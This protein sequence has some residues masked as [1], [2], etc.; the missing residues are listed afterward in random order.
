MLATNGILGAAFVPPLRSPQGLAVSQSTLAIAD[1][2]NHQVVIVDLNAPGVSAKRLGA[3]GSSASAEGF[4]FPGAVVFTAA[5]RL[6]VADS[7]NRHLDRYAR[8]VGGWA[9]QG[10]VAPFAGLNPAVSD[11]RDVC[12][13]TATSL[14][15]LEAGG[16]LLSVDLAA[17]TATVVLADN[18]WRRPVTLARGGN[19]LWVVDSET[20]TVYEYD[21]AF[22]PVRA[23]GGFGANAGRLRTPLGLVPDLAGG[24]LYV[25]EGVGGRIS[26]FDLAGVPVEQLTLPPDAAHLLGR[27]ALAGAGRLLFTDAGANRVQSVTTVASSAVALSL[28]TIEFGPVGLGYRLIGTIAVR[29]GGT[30]PLTVSAV[31]V[32][33]AAFR[34]DATAPALPA[35]VTG[36]DAL[37]LPIAFAPR[38]GGRTFG[39]IL[40]TT[41]SAAAPVL[42]ARLSGEGRVS[43]PVAIGLVLDT[44]GSM[45]QS[46]GALTKMLRLHQ[47]ADLAADLLAST[48]V[49]ELS[50]TRFS[51][52]ASVPF[53]RATLAAA[54]VNGAHQAID[55]LVPGG[56]TSIGAG[57]QSALADLATT[58]LARRSL[59]VMTDGMENTAPMIANVPIPAGTAV[60]TVGLGLPQFVDAPKL[61]GLASRNGGY[62]QVTDGDDLLLAKFFV[63]VFSD[64]IG[65]Q[66]AVDP[67]VS[68][69][70]KQTREFPVWI[71]REDRELTCVVA[72]EEAASRFDVE[73]VSPRGGVVRRGPGL[74]MVVRDRY[75]I[76][77]AA[78][79]GRRLAG[80]GRWTVRV[81]ART[82]ARAREAAVVTLMVDSD[83]HVR[84][85]LEG[86]TEGPGLGG[87]PA[88]S[89][90]T[91]ELAAYPPRG[92]PLPPSGLRV[93][94]GLAVRVAPVELGVRLTRGVIELRP[95]A[96]SLVAGLRQGAGVNLDDP[97]NKGFVA[98]KLHPAP[99][100][101][102]RVDVAPKGHTAR[103][104]VRLTGPDGVHAVRVRLEGLTAHRERWQ[105]ERS[106]QILVRP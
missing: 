95:P 15:V 52:A 9:W 31:S 83:L 80:S 54:N 11:L 45:A 79:R 26:V 28:N 84:W 63:Q 50:V 38:Q 10:V 55:A 41:S 12:V 16:R 7:G 60:Y 57:L 22:A 2:A 32:R 4:L 27:G 92:V 106:F 18:R 1:T 94:D 102:H 17:G 39:E 40:V 49:N 105:R 88:D 58:T 29:N 78:L 97:K 64:V 36:G 89:T 30:T 37:A 53:P 74:S 6:C 25:A 99:V 93:G 19:R 51:N 66:V 21:A 91:T 68:F 98:E 46:S 34:L 59:L 62:F 76:V 100:Q 85:E 33:G 44:S 77:R 72:W 5:D 8:G 90:P 23:F 13:V 69:Q 14:L 70:P 43:E 61:E 101:E 96:A 81:R 87:K 35:A 104:E 3:R 42:S 71:A 67:P 56:S 82:L 47:A 75:L 73:L 86:R 24:R 103:S 48:G 20:H 65:Q